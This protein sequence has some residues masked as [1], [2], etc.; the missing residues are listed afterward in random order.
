MCRIVSR[1]VLFGPSYVCA[2]FATLLLLLVSADAFSNNPLSA[3]Q[4]QV[5]MRACPFDTRFH[6]IT[7]SANLPPLSGLVDDCCCSVSDT[8]H[9]NDNYIARALD[10]LV[11]KRFFRFFKVNLDKEC[12]FWAVQST[13]GKNGGCE[14]CHCNAEDIPVSWRQAASDAVTRGGIEQWKD[15]DEDMWLSPEEGSTSYVDLTKNR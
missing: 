6:T 13:C 14:V 1:M 4:Q 12:P 5:F 15:D 2:I 9:V 11:N 8:Q 10:A 7:Q 3:Q